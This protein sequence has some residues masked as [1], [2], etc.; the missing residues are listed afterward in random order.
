MRTETY[1][2]HIEWALLREDNP[3]RLATG[4]TRK[5]KV[6]ARNEHHA[7]DVFSQGA[8]KELAWVLNITKKGRVYR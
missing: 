6:I 2:F 8:G 7:V 4:D 5:T 3:R 1:I